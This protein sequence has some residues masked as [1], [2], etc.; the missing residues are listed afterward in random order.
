MVCVC[1]CVD[2][3]LFYSIII[4]IRNIFYS[5]IISNAFLE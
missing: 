2:R 1:V 5:K 4:Q 3:Y